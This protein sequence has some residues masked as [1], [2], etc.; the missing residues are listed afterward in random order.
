[1]STP[2]CALNRWLW[3]G[4]VAFHCFTG[5]Q[6][7]HLL[8]LHACPPSSILMSPLLPVARA[9]LLAASRLAGAA[10]A[11]TEPA[12][13]L[14]ARSAEPPPRLGVSAAEGGTGLGGQAAVPGVARAAAGP[15]L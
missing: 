6:L 9:P 13:R 5:E 11:P 12:P 1:M 14:G 7:P 15:A 3:K 4:L 8:A 2:K 10:A